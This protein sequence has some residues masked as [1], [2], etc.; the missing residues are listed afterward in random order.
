[1]LQLTPKPEMKMGYSN[2]KRPMLA[3]VLCI[4]VLIISGPTLLRALH[5]IPPLASFPAPTDHL[6]LRQVLKFVEPVLDLLGAIYLWQMRPFATILFA[7]EAIV[8]ALSGLYLGFIDPGERMRTLR[9]VHHTTAIYL[10]IVAFEFALTIYVW[11]IT[12]RS[13]S[14][15]SE[16]VLSN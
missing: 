16:S 9:T 5:V 1:M 2:R 15:P 3:S 10:F 8:I 7:A 6:P 4:G 13:R 14:I 12:T 11:H